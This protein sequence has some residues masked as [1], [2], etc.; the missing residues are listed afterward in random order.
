MCELLEDETNGRRRHIGTA[1]VVQVVVK[2]SVSDAELE[3]LE[4]RLVLHEVE[5]V[6]HIEAGVFGRDQSVVHEL[7]PRCCRRGIVERVSRLERFVHR[8]MHHRRRERVIAHQVRYDAVLF[9]DERVYNARTR[10]EPVTEVFLV[11]AR[12][13]MKFGQVLVK[14]LCNQHQ[15]LIQELTLG[16]GLA[17]QLAEIYLIEQLVS[18]YDIF[19]F[20]STETG[21]LCLFWQTIQ[22]QG[23]LHR[24]VSR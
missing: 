12:S 2:V 19:R 14:K 16:S 7:V 11:K 21:C 1:P 18:L 8:V 15:N 17:K 13:Q 3:R 22:L 9:D 4:E 23:A 24:H 5:S 20:Q 10:Q 6:E